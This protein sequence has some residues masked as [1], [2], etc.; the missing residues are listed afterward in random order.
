MTA[1]HLSVA[2]VTAL[3]IGFVFAATVQAQRTETI[4]LTRFEDS[5]QAFEREDSKVMPPTGAIVITGS[6]SIRRWHPS[7]Q[8]DLAPLTVIPRGFGGST[9]ADVLH[10][11]DR[12]I[13]PYRPRAVVIYEGD[14]DTGR[15][16]VPPATIAS[17][18]KQIV[19]KIH[20]TLPD[21]RIYVMSV[22]PSLAREQ[23]WDKAQATNTLYQDIVSSD[24]RLAYI[25]VATPFLRNDGK[26]MNDIFV[27]DGLHLNQKGTKIWAATIKAALIKHEANYELAN[28]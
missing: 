12:L 19:S 9:M 6:S 18:L 10:F 26:V 28:D 25:D 7:M 21:T 11:V 20:A 8:E 17:E 16:R 27:D 22:K 1:R 14:N 4:D 15:F 2:T 3:V 24:T 5:V 23:V 13:I